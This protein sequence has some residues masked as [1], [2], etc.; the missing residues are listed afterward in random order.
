MQ[1]YG[2]GREGAGCEVAP[3][4]FAD[5][6]RGAGRPTGFL[7]V[8]GLGGFVPA[9]KPLTVQDLPAATVVRPETGVHRVALARGCVISKM[10]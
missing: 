10:C 8:M 7:G 2:E 6:Q 5:R 3:C 4:I 1:G 9:L